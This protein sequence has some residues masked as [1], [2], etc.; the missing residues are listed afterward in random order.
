[1]DRVQPVA[2]TLIDSGACTWSRVIRRSRSVVVWLLHLELSNEH[3]PWPG[4]LRGLL[5]AP[6]LILTDMVC[7]PSRGPVEGIHWHGAVASTLG[8]PNSLSCDFPETYYP[9]LRVLLIYP[10]LPICRW[11]KF[12]LI[13]TSNS[14]TEICTGKCISA[15]RYSEI[16]NT[17]L[18]NALSREKFLSHKLSP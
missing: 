4:P 6:F 18:H 7:R 14:L 2:G 11:Q 13:W 17:H 3:I 9:N 5:G 16:T 10:P 15:S 12:G 1:M 8:F